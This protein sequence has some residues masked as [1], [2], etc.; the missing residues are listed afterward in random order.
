MHKKRKVELLSYHLEE[1]YKLIKDLDSENSTHLHLLMDTKD[2]SFKRCD[3]C[4]QS[5]DG[6]IKAIH[7][8]YTELAEYQGGKGD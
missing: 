8:R 4:Y 2:N 1:A 6:L 3:N 7:Q 5:F